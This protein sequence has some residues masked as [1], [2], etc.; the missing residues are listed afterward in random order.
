MTVHCSFMLVQNKGC[1]ML[2]EIEPE[3]RVLVELSDSPICAVSRMIK[4]SAADVQPGSDK[5]DVQLNNGKAET[6]LI[7]DSGWLQVGDIVAFEPEVYGLDGEGIIAFR[8]IAGMDGEQVKL[9]CDIG[10]VENEELVISK[11]AIL[12]K[13]VIY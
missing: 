2:P 7:T 8:R 3:Q 10:L 1:L 4:G 12:G 9:A 6:Q 13:A 11:E 5:A